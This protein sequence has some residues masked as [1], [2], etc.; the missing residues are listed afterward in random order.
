MNIMNLDNQEVYKNFKDGGVLQTIGLLAEQIEQAWEEVKEIKI[1]EKFKSVTN[2]V[3]C[4]MGG[5][6]LGGRI[7]DSLFEQKIKVPVEVVTQ[8]YAPSYVDEKSLVIISSYSGNTE[9]TISAAKMA[10]EKGAQVFPIATGGEIAQFAAENNLTGY[11]FEPKYNPAKQPRLAL[12]Y[13]VGSILAL[14][15]SCD[16]ISL[17]DLELR[18]ALKTLKGFIANFGKD[19]DESVNEAKLMAKKLKG[20]VISLVASEHLLG[21]VHA[22]K[23]QINESAKNMSIIFEIPEL[24]HHLMEGLSHPFFIKGNFVFLLFESNLYYK[25]VSLRYEV[26][27]DVIAKNHFGFEVYTL[28]SK[29]KIE[30]VFEV[31]AFG[32]FVQFYLALLNG[33]DPVSIPWVDYF[34]EQLAKA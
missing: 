6:A 29:S 21:A 14:F 1:P 8:Y 32:S 11:I 15:S 20:K 13:S 2:I 34:K 26:T 3:I 23:N 19:K 17:S 10:L 12:G 27:K 30:Q 5:S 7:V 22:F 28:T 9:E 16:F 24:N 18:E 31:L 25:R 4:G 33:S